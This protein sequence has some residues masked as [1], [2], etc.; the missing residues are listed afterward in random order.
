MNDHTSST[1]D[2]EK[3]KKKGESLFWSSKWCN[4]ESFRQ[5]REAS[6]TL[7]CDLCWKKDV[8]SCEFTNLSR[9]ANCTKRGTRCSVT[10]A[11]RR[12]YFLEKLKISE[13]TYDSWCLEWIS[14]KRDAANKATRNRYAEEHKV[15][16]AESAS[17]LTS[18]VGDEEKKVND[19][20]KRELEIYSS[21][22]EL[23]DVIIISDNDDT[24]PSPS[25]RADSISSHS[26]NYKAATKARRYSN[27][28]P[29]TKMPTRGNPTEHA[30]SLPPQY[31][32][33]HPRKG[34]GRH[35]ANSWSKPE[36]QVVHSTQH[37][38][39]SFSAIP[40]TAQAPKGVL[41]RPYDID[42]E[43]AYHQ[44]LREVSDRRLQFLSQQKAEDSGKW[45][46][47]MAE[48]VKSIRR[49][50]NKMRTELRE[51]EREIESKKKSSAST[52]SRS[53]RKRKA[54][55]ARQFEAAKRSKRTNA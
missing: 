38:K 11:Y 17:R 48:K 35:R 2:L 24:P 4:P 23:Q 26:Y 3:L 28:S 16:E 49:E 25:K 5:W 29:P 33:T 32:E 1:P 51:L 8:K 14:Q 6:K 10:E 13:E 53:A 46:K 7:L 34:K 19:Q 30:L 54:K 55:A 9:C 52:P 50:Q 15:I 31:R 27:P 40:P 42:S 20:L 39:Q 22:K 21:K 44:H 12:V 47:E 43:I 18:S 36:P 45:A 37:T 41:A